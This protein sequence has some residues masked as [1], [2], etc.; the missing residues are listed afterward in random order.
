MSVQRLRNLQRM[1]GKE[2]SV[3]PQVSRA[4]VN[5]GFDTS[6]GIWKAPA[7][8]LQ[9]RRLLGLGD[10]IVSVLSKDVAYVCA[11]VFVACIYTR[12]STETEGRLELSAYRRVSLVCAGR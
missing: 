9:R 4:V 10:Y 2:T 3:G 11:R 8:I 1:G 12:V 5:C 6:L 7:V